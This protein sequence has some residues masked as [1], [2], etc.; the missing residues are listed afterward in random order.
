MGGNLMQR[1][2]CPYFRAEVELACN[3]RRPGSGCSALDGE[4]RHAAIF[5]ASEHCIATHPSDVAVALAA[6]D[7]LIHVDGPGG[8]R[9]IPFADFH[10][11][12]GDAPNRETQ[13]SHGEIITSIEVDRGRRAWCAGRTREPDAR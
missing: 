6:L 2:R 3:K 9:E 11:L 12:P 1:T 10:R 7:A 13:L 5:G 4:D 8:S